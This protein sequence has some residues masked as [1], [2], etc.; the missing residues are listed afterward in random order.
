MQAAT[1]EPLSYVWQPPGKSVRV[2][3]K[4]DLV[5]RMRPAVLHAATDDSLGR[6]LETGGILLGRT[7]RER[8]LTIVELGDFEPIEC[9]HAVGPSFLL[10]GTDRQRL[11]KRLGNRGA[12]RGLSVVGFYRSHTRTQLVA[13]LEDIALMSSFFRDSSNLL[14]LIH[15]C[16][17]RPLT[18]GFLIWEDR[19]IRSTRTYLEFPFESE[20]L[21]IGAR[22]DPAPVPAPGPVMQVEPGHKGPP[23]AVAVPSQ[24]IGRRPKTN[25]GFAWSVAGGVLLVAASIPFL[26]PPR[27][28]PATTARPQLPSATAPI[29]EVHPEEP[30]PAAADTNHADPLPPAAAEVHEPGPATPAPQL[31]EPAPATPA[32]AAKVEVKAPVADGAADRVVASRTPEKPPAII[33]ASALEPV[34]P[35]AAEAPTPVPD[36][37]KIATEPSAPADALSHLGAILKS[38]EPAPPDRFVNV[39]LQE[40]AAKGAGLLRNLSLGRKHDKH[41]A[42]IAPAPIHQDKPAVPPELRRRVTSEVSIDVKVFVNRAGKVEYAELL[43]NGTG[44]NRDLASLA[45][46]SSRRW[47]FSPASRDGAPVPAEVVLRFRFGPGDAG[48]KIAPSPRSA[49]R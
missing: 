42:F 8:G 12:N 49:I 28:A 14:L 30:S 33:A 39:D 43:S 41:E 3:L 10:S 13:T 21:V 29:G 11:E 26:I 18:G 27:T 22:A 24:P 36:P 35:V 37:P 16:H 9:E 15:A 20:A 48:S 38:P 6:S 7:R 40:S 2:H 32:V 23:D 25:P 47:Q 5:D 46:F 17:G 31:I 4:L 45:V 44:A 34:P 19:A 1:A